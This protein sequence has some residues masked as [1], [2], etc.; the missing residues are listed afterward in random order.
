MLAANYP[1]LSEEVR[2][3]AAL[4]AELDAKADASNGTK[5]T[6]EAPHQNKERQ[7]SNF[8]MESIER[9]GSQPYGGDARYKVFRNVRDFNATGNGYDVRFGYRLC[10]PTDRFRTIPQ[11]SMLPSELEIVAVRSVMARQRKMLLSISQKVGL[12]SI[13]F[14]TSST[15]LLCE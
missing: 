11:P 3:A 15:Y 7:A 12:E 8:W 6:G 9:L 2:S 4:V 14:N 13:V 5:W 1:E 10:S